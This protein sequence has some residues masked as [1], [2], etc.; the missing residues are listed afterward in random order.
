MSIKI[1]N[2]RLGLATN[3]SSSHSFIYI[4]LAY[5]NEKDDTDYSN[6]VYE[7][8]FGWEDFTLDNAYDKRGYLAVIL[9]D[10]LKSKG[11]PKEIRELVVSHF[12]GIKVT[13]DSY[14]DHQSMITLP[15][16]FHNSNFVDAEFFEDFRDFILKRGISILGGNDNDNATHHLVEQYPYAPNFK[17]PFTDTFSSL[18][19]RKDRNNNT[20]TLFNKTSGA[21]IRF[22][23]E[24]FLKDNTDSRISYLRSANFRHNHKPEWGTLEEFEEINK[25]N[26]INKAFAP[27]L[28]DISITS[29]CP[30]GCEMCAPEGTLISTPNGDKD[31]SLIKIGDTVFTGNINKSCLDIEQVSQIFV[32]DYNGDL[33]EIELENGELLKLTPN[34]EVYVVGKG[35]IEAGNLLEEDDIVLVKELL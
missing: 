33:I 4:P 26:F 35:W 17:F 14:I 5:P 11:M 23:F 7:G 21:K 28:V 18:V 25:I 22:S 15:S 12:A 3:S 34:H 30:F 8:E 6:K 16:D 2:V 20:W 27:E 31:I 9:N 29:A 32:R 19:A 13:D 24:D 1:H 10:S